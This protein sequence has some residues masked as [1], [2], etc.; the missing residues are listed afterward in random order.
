[1][2]RLIAVLLLLAGCDIMASDQQIIGLKDA[3]A[4]CN[5]YTAAGAQVAVTVADLDMTIYPDRAVFR[6]LNSSGSDVTVSTASVRGKPVVRQFGRTGYKVDDILDY[7]GIR[8]N[9]PNSI[10]IENEYL[11]DPTQ[12]INV[13][14][15]TWKY[16]RGKHVYSAM[17]SGCHYL[18]RRSRH[19]DSFL[20]MSRAR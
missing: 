8:K 6:W 2:T 1:M 3:S 17:F 13:A 15:W 20:W 4:I 10:D 18:S 9:G 12:I 5:G 16:N 11:I 19:R 14:D 7:D